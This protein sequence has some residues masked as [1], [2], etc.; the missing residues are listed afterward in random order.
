MDQQLALIKWGTLINP[1]KNLNHD[2]VQEFYANAFPSKGEAFSFTSMVRGR[3]I[4]F[5]K[6][7]INK[8]LGNPMIVKEGGSFLKVN[9]S[10]GQ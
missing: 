5:N 7:A 3:F 4:T 2:I 1:Q 10:K 9:L 8:F 6:N